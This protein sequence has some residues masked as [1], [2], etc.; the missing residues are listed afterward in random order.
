MTFIVGGV[1]RRRTVGWRRWLALPIGLALLWFGVWPLTVALMTT[2]VPPTRVGSATPADRG[3]PY[4]DVSFVTDD[5]VTL[6]GWYL[7][8]R[9]GAAVV[10]RH[11]ATSTRS[12]TLDAAVA[13]ANHGYGVLAT[14]ARGHGRS[15]GD[16]MD[17]G[18]HGDVDLAAA[19][20]YLAQPPEVDPHRIGVVG[21]SMGGEEALG[22]AAVDARIRAVVA[23]GVSSRGTVADEDLVLPDHP[24]RWF[25]VAQT[26]IQQHVTALLAQ[27]SAPPG[28]ADS[29][30][31]I[32]PRPV[33]LVVG[34]AATGG[35]TVAGPRLQAI[36]PTSIDLWIVRGAPDG[37]GLATRPVQWEARVIGFR[38]R[39]SPPRDAGWPA[40][41]AT[42]A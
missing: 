14:D 1:V 18:W 38:C 15:G 17:L 13:I 11:G 3:V 9:T 12:A 30:Q 33:L 6:S 40:S 31:A 37:G 21:L 29:V 26:W 20:T 41:S 5:G 8:S 28:L 34:E 39:H 19:V 7:P 27:P 2:A 16:A 10:L 42:T 4:R 25:N 36:A 24:G 32:Q 22:A 35:E 23:E